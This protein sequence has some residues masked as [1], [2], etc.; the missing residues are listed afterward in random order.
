MN[1]ILIA[2]DESRIASFIEKGLR[3]NGFITAVAEDG[4]QAVSMAETGDFDLLLLDIGL[5]GKDGW[6][7]LKSLRSQGK[8]LPV[9]IVSARDEVKDK[10]IGRVSG[11]NDYVTKPFQFRELLVRVCTQLDQLKQVQA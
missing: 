9:I 7:V 4:N 1:R 8:Q 6:A 10:V 3:K 11:A 2:E 5:P